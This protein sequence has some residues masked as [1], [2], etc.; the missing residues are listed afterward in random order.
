MTVKITDEMSNTFVFHCEDASEV[1]KVV[2]EW[3]ESVDETPL[4]EIT[5]QF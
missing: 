1:Q 4:Y 5:I 3:L 2:S